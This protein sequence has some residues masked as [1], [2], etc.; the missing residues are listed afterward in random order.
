[1]GKKIKF[2]EW[3]DK[4]G[5][6]RVAEKL[7]VTPGAVHH[8]RT[9]RFIPLARHLIQINAMSKGRVSVEQI[10]EANQAFKMNEARP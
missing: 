10:I 7:G 9:G 1:M 3:I 4:E 6:E 2:K 5:V 8:W